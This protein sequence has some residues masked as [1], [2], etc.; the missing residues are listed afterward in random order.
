MRGSGPLEAA[1][2]AFVLAL[3]WAVIQPAT[4]DLAA[5]VYRGNL[6]NRAGL[7]LWDN[8]WFG[9]HYLLGYS[10][11]SPA[12]GGLLGV[13]ALGVACATGTAALFALIVGDAFD[14][15][16]RA[17]TR[18]LAVATLGELL[19][20]RVTFLLGIT[21]GLGALLAAQ[22]GRRIL[23]P[24]LAALCAVASPVAGCFLA[25]AALTWTLVA[26]DRL[27]LAVGAAAAAPILLAQV[28]VPEG[29]TQPY[30]F[31]GFLW[32]SVACLAALAC[33]ERRW[34]HLRVGLVLY[35]GAIAVSF[36]I[37]SPMGSN[38][39]RLAALFLGPLVV[40]AASPARRHLAAF[41]VAFLAFYQW[42]GPVIET[43]RAAASPGGT[44][45]YHEPLLDFLA[46]QGRAD[47][48]VEIV[49]T[50]TRWE[51]VYVA[52]RFLMARGWET[53]LDMRLNGLFYAKH[54]TPAA[55]W[56][57][58]RRSAVRYVALSD[59]AADRSG[60]TE[61]RLLTHGAP[62]LREVFRGGH[63][64][65]FS[66]RGAQDLTSG[67]A[68]IVSVTTDGF[69][70]RANHAGD[71]LVRVRYTPYWT[72]TSGRACIRPG[73]GGFTRVAV[74]GPGRFRVAARFD[75]MQMLGGPS[76]SACRAG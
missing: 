55:Y 4:A 41:T 29:G 71:V 1:G 30:S 2:I 38:V 68:D 74:P 39:T 73:S 62:F 7:S 45:G 22:R 32:A 60:R 59:A 67:P 12:L 35:L 66:V 23:A 37:P 40:L 31:T 54:L 64:R 76:G 5:Q 53:Q 16:V 51:S 14:G 8:A 49:P 75:L 20:G 47:W 69:T 63:W 61:A 42:N 28:V 15:R 65:V 3:V 10:L 9:G 56:A 52:S 6:F 21:I 17:S 58:L 25:L 18:W 43:L 19:I 13:P 33:V 57:W 70:L 72:V 27:A 34:R 44:A 24:V 36:V 11:L 50:A 26:R 48:R 46:G